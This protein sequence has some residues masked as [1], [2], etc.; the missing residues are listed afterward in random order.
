MMK[1]LIFACCLFLHSPTLYAKDYWIQVVG[2]DKE[3][4]NLNYESLY[5]AAKAFT[6]ACNIKKRH[7]ESHI[8]ITP[9][10]ASDEVPRD[11]LKDLANNSIIKTEL[12]KAELLE[13]LATMITKAENGDQILFAIENH[14]SPA[15]SKQQAKSCVFINTTDCITEQDIKNVL[16]SHPL[17]SG[18][19]IAF[20]ING[21]YAGGFHD[22]MS[23]SVCVTTSS[24][25]YY[26]STVPPTTLWQEIQKG[27]IKKFSDISNLSNPTKPM[28]RYR[29]SEDIYIERSCLDLREKISN[30]SHI[31]KILN[32][33]E[34]IYAEMLENHQN[35][36][37]PQSSPLKLIKDLQK[38][39]QVIEKRMAEEKIETFCLENPALNNI[40]LGL[41]KISQSWN[42]QHQA[43]T[44]IRAYRS[45][46]R[47][48]NEFFKAS[49]SLDRYASNKERQEFVQQLQLKLK[50]KSSVEKSKKLSK[51]EKEILTKLTERM[52]LTAE[53]L[54]EQEKN[55][56]EQIKK[57]PAV[58]GSTIDRD[59]KA[60][61]DCF[62]PND[63]TKLASN[64]NEPNNEF[65]ALHLRA[66]QKPKIIFTAQQIEQ[67]K[68]C[69][70]QFYF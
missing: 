69:E 39:S 70:K 4:K 37:E 15:S 10:Q 6:E 34:N 51:T 8:D 41:K 35:L 24:D 9:D 2:I 67:A 12:S 19:K 25:Q 18:T 13:K 42:S 53:Y 47:S 61:L 58:Y 7:C 33:L 26:A 28:Q 14:G 60:F 21:C 54:S 30:T 48:R 50:T 52:S 56:S 11:V 20:L 17:K 63:P 49:E 66:K 62:I 45:I 43:L 46:L 16:N 27:S 23:E 57:S 29:I 59:I 40:C 65:A 55:L 64:V 38:N 1:N 3:N 44:Q 31:S 32:T 5:Q 36:C 68:K 22:L